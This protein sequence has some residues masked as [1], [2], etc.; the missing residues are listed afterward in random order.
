MYIS[1]TYKIGFFWFISVSYIEVLVVHMNTK[2]FFCTPLSTTCPK[3][4]RKMIGTRKL[5]LK[6]FI[7]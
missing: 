6:N 5:I 3:V 4:K 7:N 2:D 1:N